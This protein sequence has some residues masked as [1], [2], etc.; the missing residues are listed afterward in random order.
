V[1]LVAAAVVPSAPLLVPDLAGRSAVLDVDLR[2]A[3]QDAVAWLLAGGEE[4]VVVV[5]GAARTGPV[6]GAWDWRGFGLPPRR[7]GQDRLPLALA[8]GDWLLDQADPDRPRTLVGVDPETDAAGC[9]RLGAGLVDRGDVRLLV[10]GDGSA[11]R[12]EKAPGYLDPR[13][14]AFDA[15]AEQALGQA[16]VAG[17]LS[18]SE[19]L[20]RD[21][22]A[23]GRGAW[24]ALAG[25][26]GEADYAA[27]LLWSG[28]PYGVAYLVARWTAA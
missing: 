10:V 26:A 13:A 19:P 27:E 23:A 28:A 18:L 8:L 25:A 3:A 6:V 24:Q 4:P 22:I 7:P 9:A 1:S 17:L 12:S 2:D 11:R 20:A 5:G 15:R 14:E 16:D 21:L